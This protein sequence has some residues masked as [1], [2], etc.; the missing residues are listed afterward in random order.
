M[1]RLTVGG[2]TYSC[3]PLFGE[4]DNS[5]LWFIAQQK[6]TDSAQYHQIMV[7]SRYLYYQRTLGCT[8]NPAIQRKLGMSGPISLEPKKNAS[9]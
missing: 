4:T 8:Y 6:P 1:I 7:Y 5:R 2:I 9:T 3:V